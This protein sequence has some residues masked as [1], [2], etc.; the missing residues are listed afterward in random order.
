M[1]YSVFIIVG[2]YLLSSIVRIPPSY[3]KSYIAQI[4]MSRSSKTGHFLKFLIKLS[5]YSLFSPSSDHWRGRRGSLKLTNVNYFLGML[6]R[7]R[8][9]SDNVGNRLYRCSLI[10]IFQK[11]LVCPNRINIVK[12]AKTGQNFTLNSIPRYLYTALCSVS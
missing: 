6:W 4:I 9:R 10:Y 2:N 8:R 1:I 7:P 12:W 3:Y 11:C 5:R